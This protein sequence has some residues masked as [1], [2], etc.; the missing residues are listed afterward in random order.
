MNLVN[1]PKGHVN[2]EKD[3]HTDGLIKELAMQD[4]SLQI[5]WTT[6]LCMM[7]YYNF[8][9]RF[10][11][12]LKEKKSRPNFLQVSYLENHSLDQDITLIT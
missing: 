1:E 6:K 8:L 7:I 11:T 10:S 2:E 9:D 4:H 12:L 3:S 5:F